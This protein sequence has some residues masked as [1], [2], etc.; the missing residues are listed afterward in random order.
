VT[1]YNF[2]RWRGKK[3]FTEGRGH[4]CYVSFGRSQMY[5][6]TKLLTAE[7][8]KDGRFD[9]LVDRKERAFALRFSE[10]GGLRLP[11]IPGQVGVGAFVGDLGPAL[12]KRLPMKKDEASGL[13]VGH[14]DGGGSS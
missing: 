11:S 8:T 5:V 12:G 7:G 9:L 10:K 6:S 3:A 13:W 14:L 2:E 1:T 4:A